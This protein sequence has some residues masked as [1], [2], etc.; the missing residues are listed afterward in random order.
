MRVTIYPIKR[1][2]FFLA[3]LTKGSKKIKELLM[4]ENAIRGLGYSYADEMGRAA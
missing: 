4:E 3:L 1:I 2:I